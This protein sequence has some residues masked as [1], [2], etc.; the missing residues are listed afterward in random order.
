M[1]NVISRAAT[2][3]A[4]TAS[5]L[6]GTAVGASATPGSGV[7]AKELFKFT[8]DGTDYIGKEITIQPGGSTG[9][10]YHD[11]PLYAVIVAGTLTHYDDSC[12]V[13]GVYPKGAPV[14]EPPGADAVHIGKN[15]GPEPTALKVLYVLPTGSPPSEDAPAPVCAS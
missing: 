14:Y 10:H 8:V 1:G 11:G 2:A 13:D 4:L 15:L 5:V 6:T 7:S 3:C 12:A 9:W